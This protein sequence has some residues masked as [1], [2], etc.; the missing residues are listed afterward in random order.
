MKSSS[1]DCREFKI[2]FAD[3]WLPGSGIKIR[4]RSQITIEEIGRDDRKK[5]F[6]NWW[7]EV[8]ADHANTR[9]EPP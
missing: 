7:S 1:E 3:Q 8:E 6:A 4:F 5:I 9:S 2:L